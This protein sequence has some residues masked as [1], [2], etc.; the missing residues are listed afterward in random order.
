M[1]PIGFTSD[2]CRKALESYAAEIED[3]M[4]LAD[5]AGTMLPTKIEG[6]RIQLRNLKD[7]LRRDHQLRGTKDGRAMMTQVEATIFAPAIHQV[8]ADLQV[9]VSSHPSRQWLSELY[10]VQITI[11]NALAELRQWKE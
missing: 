2:E 11:K 4:K 6:A 7:C 3:L 1:G 9:S 8:L 10:G 5:G